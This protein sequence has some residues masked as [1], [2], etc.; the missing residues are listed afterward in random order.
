ML[1]ALLDTA[2]AMRRSPSSLASASMKRL[3]VDPEP[4]PITVPGGT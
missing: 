3:T 4:T 2:P 1:A